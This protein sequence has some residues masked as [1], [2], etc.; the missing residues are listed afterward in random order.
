MLQLSSVSNGNGQ[1]HWVYGCGW[2]T[3]KHQKN[4]MCSTNPLH[5]IYADADCSPTTHGHGH[6]SLPINPITM[7]MTLY[8]L[9]LLYTHHII[10][11]TFETRV[12]HRLYNHGHPSI[13]RMDGIIVSV[14]IH[15]K[16][17]CCVRSNNTDMHYYHH[18][19]CHCQY[20]YHTHAR[21]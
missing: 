8:T 2:Y 20:H 19:H 17:N 11:L 15:M 14:P 10:S 18:H 5:C 12:C 6:T 7:H 21:L 1:C 16:V 4:P 9:V 3:G 13:I